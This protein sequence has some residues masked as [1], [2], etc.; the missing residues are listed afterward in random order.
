MKKQRLFGPTIITL[1][2]AGLLVDYI[3]FRD[4]PWSV[5][6]FLSKI[7]AIVVLISGIAFN[8]PVISWIEQM[9]VPF[10][11]IGLAILSVSVMIAR[12]KN[13]MSKATPDA[14]SPVFRTSTEIETAPEVS[15]L[16]KGVSW[17][18]STK[19]LPS[20]LLRR[21]ACAFFVVAVMF[22]IATCVIVYSFF[23]RASEKD[24]KARADAIGTSITEIVPRQ[25]TPAGNS[26]LRDDIYNYA[27]DE[28]IAYIYIE[29]AEGRII[30]HTPSDLPRYLRRDFSSSPERAVGGID[31]RYRGATVFEIAKRVGDGKSG[32]VHV[33]VRRDLVEAE[34]WRVVMAIAASIFIVLIV[35]VVLFLIYV[36]RCIN[37]PFFELVEHANRISKGDFGVQ[38]GVARKD[39]LGEIA[40]SL[41]RLRSSLRAMLTRL[42][43]R[44]TTK[45]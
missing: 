42:E 34:A 9:A 4:S 33:A 28:S 32:F 11:A 14:A 13:A 45:R 31:R 5:V 38:L 10:L 15:D 21:L 6:K 43:Q 24:L 12:A 39:E 37:R 18:T 29:D 44:P 1:I 41:E 17:T 27:S 8:P 26:K 40:R 30:A 36:N 16:S 23:W 3:F 35:G 20:G 2:S 22:G 19:R 25:L 7:I